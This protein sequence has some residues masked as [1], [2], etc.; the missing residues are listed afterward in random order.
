MNTTVCLRAGG[1]EGVA[2]GFVDDAGDGGTGASD[3]LTG[4]AGPD[5]VGLCAECEEELD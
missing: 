5:D 3:V 2:F 1:G 4:G